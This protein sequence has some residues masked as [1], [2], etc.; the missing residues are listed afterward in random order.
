MDNSS[1]S[2][3]N[4]DY[5]INLEGSQR[6]DKSENESNRPSLRDSGVNH[7]SSQATDILVYTGKNVIF[8]NIINKK[9]TI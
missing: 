9:T 7:H 3:E 2:T 6:I 1:P 4:N 5:Y 8:S